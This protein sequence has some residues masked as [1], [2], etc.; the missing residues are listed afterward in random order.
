M[1]DEHVRR[2][3]PG[4]AWGEIRSCPGCKHEHAVGT[5]CWQ[6]PECGFAQTADRWAVTVAERNEAWE[7]ARLWEAEN[8]GRAMEHEPPHGYDNVSVKAHG[9]AAE[10]IAARELG[11]PRRTTIVRSGDRPPRTKRH[12]VGRNVEVRAPLDHPPTVKVH[13]TKDPATRIVLG[14]LGSIDTRFEPMGWILAGDARR[15]EWARTYGRR[16]EH[17]VP[18][19]G[20]HP[21]PLPEGA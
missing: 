19:A 21:L 7:V 12:D 9:I 6:C 1:T 5:T 2:G 11:L 16:T 17:R 18:V 13:P 14:M 4:H 10:I 15:P 3:R 8:V 20:L